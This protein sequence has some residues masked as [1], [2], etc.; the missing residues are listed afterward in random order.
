NILAIPKYVHVQTKLEGAQVFDLSE[1]HILKL[2]QNLDPKQVLNKIAKHNGRNKLIVEHYVKHRNVY[3]KTIVFAINIKQAILLETCFKKAGVTCVCCVSGDPLMPQNL[4]QFKDEQIDVLINVQMV[5]EGSDIPSVQTVFLARPTKSKSLL[6]QMIG[7]ALRGVHCGGTASAYIVD[8]QDQWDQIDCWL[9]PQHVMELYMGEVENKKLP[10]KKRSKMSE[11]DDEAYQMLYEALNQ[12]GSAKII[13]QVIPI[14]WY[15]AQDI[16]GESHHLFVYEHDQEGYLQVEAD[17]SELLNNQLTGEHV[18]QTYFSTMKKP[19]VEQLKLLTFH[20]HLTKKLPTYHRF[21]QH[22]VLNGDAFI[23]LCHQESIIPRT[24]SFEHKLTQYFNA[25]P[26]LSTVYESME[27]FW[28]AVME[29][30]GEI[31]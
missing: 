28:E 25:H 29:K 15:E 23:K 17:A 9:N 7:R 4:K 10:P 5:C 1:T 20:L 22:Q 3:H 11:L 16:K 18:Q 27:P 8:F 14:G 21:M 24:L 31:V 2:C 6:I 30:E 26:M 13:D 12:S 19:S